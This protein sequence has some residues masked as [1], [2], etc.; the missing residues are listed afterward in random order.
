MRTGCL[1]LLD[2][3]VFEAPGPM[4]PA[5]NMAMMGGMGMPLGPPNAGTAP[6]MG[7]GMQP[8]TDPPVRLGVKL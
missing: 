8:G 6:N 3:P 7:Y 5:G 4:F 2:R 1:D